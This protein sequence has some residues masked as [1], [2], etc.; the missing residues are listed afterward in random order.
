MPEG[1]DQQAGGQQ[2]GER[3]N[4]PQQAG[5]PQAGERAN[6]PQQGGQQAGGEPKS[7]EQAGG[8]PKSGEQ[9]GDGQP[10]Q[11][12]GGQPGSGS[13]K[14]GPG[15]GA[16][17]GPGGEHGGQGQAQ[18]QGQGPGEQPKGQGENGSQESQGGP[19]PSPGGGGNRTGQAN[20]PSLDDKPNDQP[21][22]NAGR[23]PGT[24][25]ANPGELP[26]PDSGR[27]EPELVLRKLQDILNRGDADQVRR[28]EDATNMSR[29]EL[30]QFA[31][32]FERPDLKAA[33]EGQKLQGDLRRDATVAPRQGIGDRLKGSIIRGRGERGP[34][35]TAQDTLSD[36][37]QGL[38]TEAPPE[39]RSRMEAY[40]NSI[41]RSRNAPSG[42]Q[43]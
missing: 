24:P 38:R 29:E 12:P 31:R 18:G 22:E 21:A 2:G 14:S 32:K 13:P 16:P 33:S 37:T 4:G 35:T 43:R 3:A 30:Q 27:V 25:P 26:A 10:G 19:S 23:R 36:Q 20:L 17:K 40:Q 7:G 39:I 41:S 34:G 42:G 28:L 9:A 6:S 11:Q 8:E 5:Q 15:Q 1:Q